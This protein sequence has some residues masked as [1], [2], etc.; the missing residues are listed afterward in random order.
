MCPQCSDAYV[1]VE[2]MQFAH[3]QAK[4]KLITDGEATGGMTVSGCV[5]SH[6]NAE[7]PRC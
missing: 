5:M 7:M 4:G 1:A 6:R 3:S 2:R